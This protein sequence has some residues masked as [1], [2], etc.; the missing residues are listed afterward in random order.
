MKPLKLWKRMALRG[1]ILTVILLLL[2]I[3]AIV[4]I[5]AAVYHIPLLVQNRAVQSVNALFT[6]NDA[7][8]AEGVAQNTG[9]ISDSIKKANQVRDEAMRSF[10]LQR[11]SMAQKMADA[12]NGVSALYQTKEDGSRV[13]VRTIQ[14]FQ[15]DN[16]NKNL[17]ELDAMGKTE[18]TAAVRQDFADA[19]NQYNIY[20]QINDLLDGQFTDGSA[21]NE[22][23]E[24]ASS[25]ACD[26]AQ[27]LVAQLENPDTQTDMNFAISQVR[28]KVEEQ[29]AAQEAA[30]IAE[31]EAREAERKAE[32]EAKKA[33]EEAKKK[34]NPAEQI[35]DAINSVINPNKTE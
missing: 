24:D 32:E 26:E 31:E 33:E 21:R 16:I 34:N 10:L 27:E 20:K 8:L 13:V 30:R 2:L 14:P 3:S 18:F 28:K 12:I 6:E 7:G 29:E 17:S 5:G 23:S 35:K 4:G 25:E 1:K 19:Q 11:T 22:L 9:Q 15:V